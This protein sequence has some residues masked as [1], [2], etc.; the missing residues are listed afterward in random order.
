MT[1]QYNTVLLYC[2]HAENQLLGGVLFRADVP[3]DD[4][5]SAI[6]SLAAFL[7]VGWLGRETLRDKLCRCCGQALADTLDFH[8]F[9][10]ELRRLPGMSVDAVASWLPYDPIAKH[11]H[12][13]VR[14]CADLLCAE[15]VIVIDSAENVLDGFARPENLLLWGDVSPACVQRYSAY[16]KSMFDD[17]RERDLEH[18][19]RVVEKET[20]KWHG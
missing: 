16:R 6:R 17:A 7:L 15:N 13:S 1:K 14:D 11:N 8:D 10:A 5:D 2:G 20:T 3:F 9:G 19:I 12:W 4:V 18:Y